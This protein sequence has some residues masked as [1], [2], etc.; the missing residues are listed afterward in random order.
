MHYF[1]GRARVF[2]SMED[3]SNAVSTTRSKRGDVLV[4]RYEGPKGGPGMREMHDLLPHR[5]TGN[6]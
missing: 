2:T 5:G 1:K 3:A 6:G 4:I